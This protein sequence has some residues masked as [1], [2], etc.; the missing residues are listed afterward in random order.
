M[1]TNNIDKNIKEKLEKRTFQ[2]SASA[3]ERLSVKLDEQPKQKKK[4]WFFYIAVAASI[5]LLINVSFMVFNNDVE[6]K[7]SEI[8]VEK[9]ID[10]V[11]INKKLDQF[12]NEVP[13]EKAFV[14]NDEIETGKII[15]PSIISLKEININ[16]KEKI[17]IVKKEEEIII[18][19][20]DEKELNIESSLDNQ[21]KLN[22]EA[23]QQNPNSSIKINSD[24]LL[25]AVTHTPTEVKAYYAK[26]NVNREDV[27]RTIKSELKKSNFKINP[28]TILA[29]VERTI[30]DEDFQNNFIKTLKIKVSDIATAIASRND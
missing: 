16:P 12:I 23:L 19:K 15:K 10:T 3:W 18:A 5:L 4:G 27:L 25:Y 13:V 20:V 2:P 21:T 8:I 26:Y 22:K 17:N 14:K 7:P 9:V 24:D 6:V 30:N 29:E 28:N 11:T 1:K